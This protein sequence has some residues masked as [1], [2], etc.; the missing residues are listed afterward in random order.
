MKVVCLPTPHNIRRECATWL[1]EKLHATQYKENV[2]RDFIRKCMRYSCNPWLLDL[3]FIYYFTWTIITTFTYHFA[4]QLFLVVYHE[5]YIF[6]ISNL[7][8]T[9]LLWNAYFNHVTLPLYLLFFFVINSICLCN[10]WW[11][12]L[13]LDSF[14]SNNIMLHWMH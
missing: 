12:N 11:S 7:T 14:C 2:T 3:G 4:C 6:L 9:R 8:I 13:M 10:I 5:N 1:Y